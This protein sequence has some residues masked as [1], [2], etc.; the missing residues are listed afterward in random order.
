MA[1]IPKNQGPWMRCSRIS[2]NALI[3]RAEAA[4]GQGLSENFLQVAQGLARE[5]I[6]ENRR[7]KVHHIRLR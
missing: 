1:L 5:E 4:I 6:A 3:L 7:R 2:G